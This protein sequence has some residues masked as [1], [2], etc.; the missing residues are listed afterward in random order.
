MVS[1]YYELLD[2][3]SRARRMCVALPRVE[4]P[5]RFKKVNIECGKVLI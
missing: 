2:Y 4:P 3:M 1:L 5:K